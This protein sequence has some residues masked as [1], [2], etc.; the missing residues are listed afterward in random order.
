MV[1][2]RKYHFIYKT[3]C[4]ISGKW[5]IGMH[6]TY[7]LDDG[8]LGSGAYLWHSI[9]KYGEENH[10]VEILEFCDD[11]DSLICREKQI[12]N[13]AIL[14]EE[15]C[16]NLRQGGSGGFSSTE[17]QQKTSRAGGLGYGR[18]IKEDVEFAAMVKEKYSLILKRTHS[19]GKIKY[20]NFKGK[21]HSEETKKRMSESHIGKQANEKNS[22]YGT[23]WINNG[24]TNRKIKKEELEQ[25]LLLNEGWVKGRKM[26]FDL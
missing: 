6:S 26:K 21:H 14:K 11:R 7:N 23:C 16:M 19:Q 22:Q 17:H 9:N 3:T 1:T 20:N 25:F 12:V 5:Y 13:S 15:L 24:L 4:E 8:Y 18:K 10:T 2:R